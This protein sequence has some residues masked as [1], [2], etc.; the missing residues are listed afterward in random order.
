MRIIQKNVILIQ[1]VNL[2]KWAGKTKVQ[3]RIVT[4]Q[5]YFSLNRKGKHFPSRRSGRTATEENFK[6]T[7][8][9][10]FI[11]VGLNRYSE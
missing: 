2:S 3:A 5:G 6:V 4:I 8:L 10:E 7:L 1:Q 11:S 9:W